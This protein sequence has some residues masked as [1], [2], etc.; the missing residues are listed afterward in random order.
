M[1]RLRHGQARNSGRTTEYN[2]YSEAK[3]RCTN[4]KHKQWANYGGRGIKFLFVSF[5]Q[6]WAELGPV[7][8]GFWLDRTNN[9]GNYEPGNV[10]WASRVESIKNRRPTRRALSQTKGYKKS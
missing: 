6:F 7:P 10:R 3:Q 1:N 5:E 2:R 4:P 9:D 8:Q